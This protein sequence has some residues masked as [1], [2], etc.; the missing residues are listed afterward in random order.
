MQKPRESRGE[1]KDD[2]IFIGEYFI[3][4]FA[5]LI[6][7]AKVRCFCPTAEMIP[8]E[9]PVDPKRNYEFNDYAYVVVLEV[10]REAQRLLVGMKKESVAENIRQVFFIVI[11]KSSSLILLVSETTLSSD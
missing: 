3:A 9:D 5:R 2:I 1:K 4:I 6:D 8:A 7:D 10:K 11:P